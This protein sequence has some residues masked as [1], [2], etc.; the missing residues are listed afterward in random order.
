MLDSR[1]KD[2]LK[3]LYGSP[4]GPYFIELLDKLAAHAADV[5]NM[6]PITEADAKAGAKVGEILQTLKDAMQPIP[7]PEETPSDYV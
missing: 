4:H 2:F 1:D 6:N 7:D 5:R 3:A